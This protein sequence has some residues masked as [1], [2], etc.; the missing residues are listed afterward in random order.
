M[1][2]IVFPLYILAERFFFWNV[3]LKIKY[4]HMFV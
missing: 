4:I 3:D 1:Y 2:K